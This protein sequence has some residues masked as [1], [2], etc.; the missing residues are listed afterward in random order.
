MENIEKSLTEIIEEQL[1]Q[2]K[3]FKTVPSREVLD[4][5]YVLVNIRNC[6]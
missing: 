1:E 6:Y 5:I 2:C 4:T 3:K